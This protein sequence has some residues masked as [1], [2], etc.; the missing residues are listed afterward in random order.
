MLKQAIFIRMCALLSAINQIQINLFFKIDWITSP[1]G[2]YESS[3]FSAFPSSVSCLLSLSDSETNKN[4][5][6]S[7]YACHW[8]A[9]GGTAQ[10]Q[11]VF[12]FWIYL[13]TSGNTSEGVGMNVCGNLDFTVLDS[14]ALSSHGF[15]CKSRFS[16]VQFNHGSTQGFLGGSD[17]A[18]TGSIVSKN[19]IW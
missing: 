8:V 5:K 11:M 17:F 15:S 7:D 6:F 18:E 14:S 2:R 9:G 16:S 1:T 3:C 19:T 12:Y 4:L 13:F 10:C